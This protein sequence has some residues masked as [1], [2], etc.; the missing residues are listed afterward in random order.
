MSLLC[1]KEASLHDIS[2]DSLWC[3]GL[4]VALGIIANF[5]LQSQKFHLVEI[6]S[7]YNNNNSNNKKVLK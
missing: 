4:M 2:Q 7:N 6:N 5:F 3:I 1:L